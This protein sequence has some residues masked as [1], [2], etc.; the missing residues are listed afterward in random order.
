[1]LKPMM[2]PCQHAASET[3]NSILSL[4]VLDSLR[5]LDLHRRQPDGIT[6]DLLA[7]AWT[8]QQP[9]SISRRW[10]PSQ[11]PEAHPWRC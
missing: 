10:L 7:G 6:D 8:Q 1:M 9:I 5:R 4:D 3:E 11:A 2:S